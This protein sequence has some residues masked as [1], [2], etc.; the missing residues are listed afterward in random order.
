MAAATAKPVKEAKDQ[1]VT[2]EDRVQKPKESQDKGPKGRDQER[3]QGPRQK[4]FVGC[5]QAAND[6]TTAT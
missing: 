5:Q 1:E 2:H 6:A 3:G 4:R